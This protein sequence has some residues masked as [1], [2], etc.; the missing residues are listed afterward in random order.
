MAALVRGTSF[1]KSII[2][3]V[4]NNARGAYFIDEQLKKGILSNTSKVGTR[5]GQPATLPNTSPY[6]ALSQANY[7]V[8][9]AEVYYKFVPITPIGKLIKLTLPSPYI[10]YDAAYFTTF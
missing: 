10:L 5:V 2:T 7:T 3:A 9:V 8:Y 6:P 1:S 4:T